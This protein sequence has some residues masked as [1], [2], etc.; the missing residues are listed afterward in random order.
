MS[1]NKFC[2]VGYIPPGKIIGSETF[3]LNIGR[4]KTR[5]P[6]LLYSD[7]DYP[8]A[9]KLK[10]SPEVVKGAKYPNGNPNPWAT[11]NLIFLTGLAIAKNH[12][13][14]HMIYVESDCRVGI[15]YWDSILVNE[16]FSDG[17]PLAAGTVVTYNCSNQGIS[18]TRE[19]NLF[20]KDNALKAFPI[21]SFGGYSASAKADAVIFPNGALGVYSIEWLLSKLDM[22]STP[23]EAAKIMAWDY[24]IGVELVKEFGGGVFGKVKHLN[25]VYSGYGDVATTEEERKELLISGKVVGVHQIKSAWE[26]PD[27]REIQAVEEVKK[28]EEVKKEVLSKKVSVLVVSYLKDIEFLRY[29]LMSY[30]KFASGF[31]GITVAVPREGAAPLKKL[32]SEYGAECYVFDEAVGKGHLHQNAI[33]CMADEIIPDADYILHTDSDCCFIEPVTPLD[34]FVD[35][36]PVLLYQPY[37]SLATEPGEQNKHFWREPTERALGFPV[38]NEFMVRHPA[39]HDVRTYRE[40]RKTVYVNHNQG[41]LNYVLNQKKTFPYGFCEFNT[42]GAYAFANHPE[43]YHWIDVSKEPRPRDHIIDF[44]SHGG[45]DKPV[46]RPLNGPIPD[47]TPRQWIKENLL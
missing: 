26:G 6:L 23:T 22:S 35:G 41:F 16:A 33:K 38:A 39:V 8:G 42:L 20:I 17:E 5:Y 31:S 4:F 47:L 12:G 18:F 11:N 13:Y 46:D 34:Y 32:C 29:C 15:D 1:E 44:W 30:V 21:S 19:W 9:I 14:T 36:K 24:F 45:L 3:R 27:Q 10:A 7:V 37:E 28:M 2:V 40:M 43:R 25:S